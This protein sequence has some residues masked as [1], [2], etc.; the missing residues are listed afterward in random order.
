MNLPKIRRLSE[1]ED[2]DFVITSAGGCRAHPDS[3]RR[4]SLRNS[5]YVLGK[6]IIELK[7]IEEERLEKREVQTKIA[8]LFTP[9]DTG[10]PVVVIDPSKLDDKGQRDYAGI[11]RGP[12]K[13]AVKS[14]SGQLR[15]SREEIDPTAT[16]VLFVVNNGLAAMR[17]EELLEHVVGRA[18]NDTSE[19]DAVVVAGC[20][21][22]GDGFDTFALWPIDYV[23]INEDRTFR[24]FEVLR[25][26]WNK[27]AGRHMTEFVTGRHAETANK[28][29]QLDVVFDVDGCTY[30]KPAVPIGVPSKFFGEKRP[31]YNQKT[32]DQVGPAAVTVPRLSPVEYNRIRPALKGDPLFSSIEVW[33]SHFEEAMENSTPSLPVVPVDIT[34]GGWEAWKRK[35]PGVTGTESLR[36]AA[37]Y[38]FCVRASKLV[39]AAKSVTKRL[40][41]K[42]VGDFKRL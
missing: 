1:K 38:A 26:G 27:L 41:Q 2:L 22:H 8:K 29:P 18:K 37:N 31:R 9:T 17:H 21:L 24:D 40:P 19:I 39:H 3:G 7:L 23:L 42:E 12:I 13:T 32:F 6:S 36:L 15:Q 11:M 34:R 20:Y 5:D 28:E 25:D 10:R 14:A 33:Q 35:N 16:S 4:L 30:V